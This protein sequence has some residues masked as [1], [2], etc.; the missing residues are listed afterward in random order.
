MPPTSDSAAATTYL[1]VYLA[2]P[3]L[4]KKNTYAVQAVVTQIVSSSLSSTTAS[5]QHCRGIYYCTSK[6]S[7]VSQLHYGDALLIKIPF[8]QAVLPPPIRISLIIVFSCRNK[9]YSIR[10]ICSQDY[11]LLDTPSQANVLMAQVFHLQQYLLICWKICTGEQETGVAKAL[12]LG[13]RY[14]LDSELVQM[15]AE[16]GTIHLL[17]VSGLHILLIGNTYMFFCVVAAA[18]AQRQTNSTCDGDSLCG[19]L[20][21]VVGFVGVSAVRAALMYA[22]VGVG[23]LLGRR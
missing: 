14:E 17:A 22:M 21:F 16:T 15:Y 10:H 2:E 12:L 5:F 6:D 13:Y 3:P 7:L 18:V 1:A 9:M 19:T 23:Q 8:L 11:H 4:E 20:Y